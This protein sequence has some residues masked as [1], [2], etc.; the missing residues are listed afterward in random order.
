MSLLNRKNNE[1]II[2]KE[3]YNKG[4]IFGVVITIC[5]LCFFVSTKFWLPDGRDKMT[6]NN[7]DE[8]SFKD[9][10]VILDDNYY[11]NTETNVAQI[12]FKEMCIAEGEENIMFSVKTDTDNE[13]P[14]NLIKGK[15]IAEEQDSMVMVTDYILQFGLPD[16]T[17]YLKFKITKGG[18]S[19]DFTI[20]YR[21]FE[22]KKIKEL[23]NNYLVEKQSLNDEINGFEVQKK[24]LEEELSNINKLSDEEKITKKQRVDEISHTIMKIEN[25]IK[26]NMR[27]LEILEEGIS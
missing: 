7:K 6:L 8:M 23:D 25:D 22:K 24:Q 14:L 17:Y 5:I 12:T 10:I 20:D 1:Y 11:W 16:N 19:Y 9:T 3:G 13:M 15:P 4:A 18:I 26:V 27:K 2:L 21:D